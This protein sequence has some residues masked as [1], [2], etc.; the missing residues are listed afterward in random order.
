SRLPLRACSAASRSLRWRNAACRNRVS[1]AVRC[2]PIG[3]RLVRLGEGHVMRSISKHLVV[4]GLATSLGALGL[5]IGPTDLAFAAGKG[6]GGG[7]VGGGGG[8]GGRGSSG[9]GGGA[10]VSAAHVSAAHV[11]GG[12]WH[13]SPHISSHAS[14]WS[15]SH[16]YSTRYSGHTH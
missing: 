11:S 5:A 1:Y 13:S 16:H 8:G 12:H 14:H 15:G 7:K 2:A 3:T 9:G 6:G 10:H 4:L